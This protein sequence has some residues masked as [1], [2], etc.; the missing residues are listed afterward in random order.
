PRA[1]CRDDS[2]AARRGRPDAS[3]WPPFSAKLA[4]WTQRRFDWPSECTGGSGLHYDSR[5]RRRHGR[6]TARGKAVRLEL[7][8][9]VGGTFTDIVVYDRA[10]RRQASHKELTTHADPGRG[11]MAGIDRLLAESAIAAA[12]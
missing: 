5:H 4:S 9:D 7:G 2:C 1:G 10:T 8:I 3:S 12:D 6:R 11:V